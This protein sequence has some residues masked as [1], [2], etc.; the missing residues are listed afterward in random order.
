[1]CQKNL[2]FSAG[3]KPLHSG[4]SSPNDVFLDTAHPILN[5]DH[6]PS[7]QNGKYQPEK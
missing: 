1:M 6:K 3:I 7:N 2:P 4:E 5:S